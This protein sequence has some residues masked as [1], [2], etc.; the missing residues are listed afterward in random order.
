MTGSPSSKPAHHTSKKTTGTFPAQHPY[1][2]PRPSSHP[3]P[4]PP[5]PPT[6]LSACAPS[7]SLRGSSKHM[8][9]RSR[10]RR[11]QEN[12][13]CTRLEYWRRLWGTLLRVGG[14]RWMMRASG[15]RQDCVSDPA[16]FTW[17]V[18]FFCADTTTLRWAK[19]CS[20]F[21]HSGSV[22]WSAES[23]SS[24]RRVWEGR[25]SQTWRCYPGLGM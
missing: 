24:S 4:L 15:G 11:S 18:Y 22:S 6:S 1:S 17:L 10:P 21:I 14:E 20:C 23:Q 9:R 5:T 12:S 16:A 7:P 8:C 25:S 13:G 19:P 2:P 3:T